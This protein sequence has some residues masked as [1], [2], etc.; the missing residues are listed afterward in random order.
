[1]SE[2]QPGQSGLCFRGLWIHDPFLHLPKK[3]KNPVLDS[4]ILIY[5][6]DYDHD[7][8]YYDFY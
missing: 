1:M 7:Y 8:D 4:E 6:Y 5:D 2:I 3:A